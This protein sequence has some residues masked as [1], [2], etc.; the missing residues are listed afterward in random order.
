MEK[1]YSKEV[2]EEVLGKIRNGRRVRD[3]AREH[4]ITEMMV[5]TWLSRDARQS[6]SETLELS[7]LRRENEVLLRILGQLT[8]EA[9]LGKKKSR[10][11]VR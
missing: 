8:S 10:R 2:R 6:A 11:G 5:R 7:P 9:E 1:R 4:G 3:V